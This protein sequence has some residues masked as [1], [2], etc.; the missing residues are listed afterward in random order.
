MQ[1]HTKYEEIQTFVWQVFIDQYFL[2]FFGATSQQFNQIPVLELGNELYLIFELYESL[3]RMRSK[4]LN[5]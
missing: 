5:R 2:W 4:S 3:A 1:M